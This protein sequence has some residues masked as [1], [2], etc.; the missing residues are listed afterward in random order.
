MIC[1]R[2]TPEPFAHSLAGT[3][4]R[5]HGGRWNRKG[6]AI[7]YTSNSTALCLLE[8]LVNVR[9]E[10]LPF[11]HRMVIEVPDALV[12]QADPVFYPEVERSREHGELCV[13][14]NRWVATRVASS[15]LATSEDAFN[16]LL[17][18]NHPEFARVQLIES[19]PLPIDSRLTVS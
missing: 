10:Y 18:P 5:R 15:V 17:N 4:A 14:H 6:T 13:Q 7:L 12:D 2:V 8:I 1:Y 11:F 16:L 9:Q 19:L 3:G